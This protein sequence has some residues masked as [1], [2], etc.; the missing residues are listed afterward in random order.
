MSLRKLL[1]Y[2]PIS[3]IGLEQ[4]PWF[5]NTWEFTF[6]PS[7]TYSTYPK[8]QNGTP[9]H[10]KR[11]HDHVLSFDLAMPP[12]PQW[13]V[14]AKVEFADTPR[15]SMGLR[16]G[17]LGAQYL[18]LDDLLGDPV[19]LTTGVVLRGVTRSSLR[20]VSAPYH[21]YFNYEINAS[22]GKEWDHGFDWYARIYGGSSLGMANRGYPWATAFAVVEGQ[23]QHAHRLGLFTAG[24]MG[25]GH[26]KQVSIDHFHG[27]AFIQHRNIDM[28]IKYT[29]VFEIWGHLSLAYTCR[30]YA[31][32]FPEQVNFFT[33]SYMLPFSLF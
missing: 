28:G 13:Q 27:Y 1:F 11:S 6:T 12:S 3:L 8:V 23:M 26:Q 22:V 4:E 25:F 30:L 7:Y 32:S 2:L 10:Q 14:N 16:S 29:Y 31:R 19:S 21:S 18:W 9:H 20:D 24:Y 33:L 15:Q 5:C 17:A